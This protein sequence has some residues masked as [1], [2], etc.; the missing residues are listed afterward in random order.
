MPRRGVPPP[1]EWSPS[2]ESRQ[3]FLLRLFSALA[4]RPFAL[5]WTGRTVSTLGDGIYLIALTWWVLATTGSAAAN[6]IILICA[7]VPMLLLLLV[8]GVVVDRVN[9]R[10]LLVTADIVRG[11]VVGLVA[12][13]AWRHLLAFWQLAALSALFGVVRA[14]YFPAYNS[15]LPQ[16]TPREMLPSANALARLSLETTGILGPALG[17]VLV[18]LGGTPLAFALDA[19]SFFISA[20][21]VLAIPAVPNPARS[22]ASTAIKETS[23]ALSDLREGLGTVL[24]TPWLWITIAIAGVS[25]ITFAGPLE[26]ALPL[27]VRQRLGGGAGVYA[28]LNALSAAGAVVAA[29]LL[30]QA[31]KLRRRGILDYGAWLMAA[32]ALLAMGLPITVLGVGLAIFLCGAGI[33]VLELVWAN[34]LQEMVPPERLGRVSSVD[35][36]GS[37]ALLPVGYGLAG[38]AAD[39]I[40]A[41]PVFVLG[42]AIS[43][44][45][46]ALGLLH[47]GVRG[48]D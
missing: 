38:F 22:H 40:G 43:S 33:A 34:T 9:R 3:V 1:R 2:K 6:G 37:Y 47:P 7:T 27:L 26:A 17:G 28:L 10:E 8:G 18:V 11:L 25:N 12:T 31:V 19:L 35:A 24:R 45:L 14:F 20:V 44:G 4:H 16:I 42:G 23:S 13:L 32:V 41:A 36:L 15:I 29:V 48:L 21:C 39:H 46:I 5:L 30:G